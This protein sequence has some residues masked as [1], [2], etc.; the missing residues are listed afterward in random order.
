MINLEENIE[1]VVG[2]RVK[3][4]DGL[5]TSSSTIA[6]SIAWRKALGGVKVP[7]GIHRFGTHE[8]ANRWLWQMIARPTR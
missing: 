5:S 4:P 6:D 3:T 1:R 8:E 2:K 7:R